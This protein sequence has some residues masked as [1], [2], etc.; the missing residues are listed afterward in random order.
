MNMIIANIISSLLFCPSSSQ[1][2]FQSKHRGGRA[3]WTVPASFP[4]EKVAAAYLNPPANRDADQFN[5]AVPNIN[6]IREYCAD[7][8]GW[9]RAEVRVVIP[10]ICHWRIS[11]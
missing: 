10:L 9:T 4:N 11:F 8:L 7:T 2:A 6:R 1:L 5:W 3:R